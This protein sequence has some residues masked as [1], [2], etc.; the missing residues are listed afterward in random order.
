MARLVLAS[1]SPR[2]FS[3]LSS[4]GIPFEVTYPRE[5]IEVK[6]GPC[7]DPCALAKRNAMAKAFSI[8]GLPNSILVAFDTLVWKGG[9]AYGKPASLEEAYGMLRELSGGWHEVHTAVCAVDM[10]K[11]ESISDCEVTRVK[12]KELTE[13]EIELYLSAGEALDAAGGYAIQ[14]LASL[15]IER[16]EG[17]YFNVVGLPLHRLRSILLSLGVDLLEEA[18]RMRKAMMNLSHALNL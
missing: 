6:W 1:R 7:E 16:I 11:G 13:R 15:L 14:G 4:L 12:F 3:I 5:E 8:H 17:D 9:Y 18:V 10:G 2:R